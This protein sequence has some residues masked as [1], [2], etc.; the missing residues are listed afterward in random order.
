MELRK[1]GYD[2]VDGLELPQVIPMMELLYFR[3]QN[4]GG[5]LD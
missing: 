3:V 1:T 5:F 4:N 2:G